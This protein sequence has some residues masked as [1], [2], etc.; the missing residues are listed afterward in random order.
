MS[1]PYTKKEKNEAYFTKELHT[2][3]TLGKGVYGSVVLTTNDTAVKNISRNT[4]SDTSFLDEVKLLNSFDHPNVLS[5]IHW[6]FGKE[7]FYLEIPYGGLSLYQM[8]RNDYKFNFKSVML[9]FLAGMDYL[10]NQ[11]GIIHGDLKPENITY[12]PKT[13]GVLIVDFDI[14]I[15]KNNIRN[16]IPAQWPQYMYQTL[17]YRAPELLLGCN[18]LLSESIDLWSIGVI[19]YQLLNNRVPFLPKKNTEWE[20]LIAIFQK[21]G[22]PKDPVIQESCEY[23]SK[24]YPDYKRQE[25]DVTT[26][27]PYISIFKYTPADRI[28]V[29]DL[30]RYLETSSVYD[31]SVGTYDPIKGELNREELKKVEEKEEEISEEEEEEEISVEEKEEKEYNQGEAETLFMKYVQEDD[32]KN[33]QK[34]VSSSKFLNYNWHKNWALFHVAYLGNIK[35]L[36]LLLNSGIDV[37]SIND[38][39]G[40][41]ALMYA[42]GWSQD[43]IVDVLIEKGAN[44]NFKSRSDEIPLFYAITCNYNPKIVELL[45]E[46]GADVAYSTKNQSSAYHMLSKVYDIENYDSNKYSKIINILDERGGDI[47]SLTDKKETALHYAVKKFNVDLVNALLYN[48]IDDTI[49]DYKGRTAYELSKEIAKTYSPD[50]EDEEENEKYKKINEIVKLLKNHTID[51]L[52]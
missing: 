25:I 47:N 29:A 26:K 30:R 1:V 10:N 48:D 39:T 12:N 11:R 34:L 33:L 35:V 38:E 23:Y 36:K 27:E 24:T 17:W 20:Q 46:N 28:T 15:E 21:L 4:L 9:Q 18:A 40:D 49:K 14:Y 13:G 16:I 19:W 43:E 37:N 8:L 32:A 7:Y 31:V 50:N 45:L 5:L 22:V 2:V 44:V 42:I 3:K 6:G 41:T 51:I 52:G